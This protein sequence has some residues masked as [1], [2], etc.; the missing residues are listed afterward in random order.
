MGNP[1]AGNPV[2]SSSCTIQ[3]LLQTAKRLADRLSEH[4]NNVEHIISETE[5][6]NK[7]IASMRTV[8]FTIVALSYLYIFASSSFP[9]VR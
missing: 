1:G 8:S 3:G 6:L 5:Q 7:H 9:I 2:S 4:G